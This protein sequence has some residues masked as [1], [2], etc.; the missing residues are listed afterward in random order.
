MLTDPNRLIVALDFAEKTPALSLIDQLDPEQ[1]RLK[2][3]K[4]M[5]GRFG[6][7]FIKE[8]HARDFDI[9]LDL[10]Y[11][12]IPNTV[13]KA[14][15]AAADLGVWMI[16]CHASGGEA[17][18]ST[19]CKALESYGKDAPLFTAVTVLTSMS[20]SELEQTG[21]SMSIADRV[22]LLAKLAEQS[23]MD[24]IVCSAQEAA[25]LRQSVGEDFLLVTPGIRPAGSAMDDQKRVMTPARAI[26]EGASY[27]VIGRP[28]TK[29]DDPLKSLSEITESIQMVL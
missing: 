19:A 26:Q 8:L 25:E 2:V 20:Q 10:K 11:H 18:M 6:P 12:D 16:N 28:I 17:M 5:F 7:E 22:V 1:C 15:Q 24:G 21:I 4:E 3:G 9:F 23:G 14:C 27:L 13:A 29:A